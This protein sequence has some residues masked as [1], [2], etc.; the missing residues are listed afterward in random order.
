M[1]V[2]GHNYMDAG[3]SQFSTLT[4]ISVAG[5]GKPNTVNNL[6]KWPLMHKG[7]VVKAIDLN[8]WG[9]SFHPKNPQQFLVTAFFKGRAYLA[10]GDLSTKSMK[11]LFE[12]VECPS[13]SPNGESVAFKKRMSST[14]WSP[15]VLNLT[16]L[17]PV[18]FSHIQQSVDDQIDWL[19]AKTLVYEIIDVPLVGNA[20]VNLMTLDIS[21]KNQPH[22]VWLKNARSA[23]VYFPKKT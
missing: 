9:V 17:K 11:V 21:G 10:L 20:S 8:Y 4:E 5:A 18:I 2:K 19:D 23:A 16:T 6:E 12:G 3:S 13:Y 22:K 1:F 15:A 14:R 7:E